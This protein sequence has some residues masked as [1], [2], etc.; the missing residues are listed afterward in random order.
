MTSTY[1]FAEATALLGEM[2]ERAEAGQRV[3]ITR[4]GKTIAILSNPTE[5]TGSPSQEPDFWSS[6]ERFRATHYL[7]EVAI[8]PT[9]IFA[10][11]QDSAPDRE[12]S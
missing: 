2:V 12:F 4:H 6:Y 9:E 8:D 5:Q 10:S 11:N 1:S 3:E 7:S